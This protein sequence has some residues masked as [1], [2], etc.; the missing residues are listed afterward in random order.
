LA[1]SNQA[2]AGAGIR[3]VAWLYRSPEELVTGVREY[4]QAGAP[5]L[6]AILVGRLLE[7]LRGDTV[8]VL[9]MAELGRNPARLMPELRGFADEHPGRRVRVLAELAWPGRSAA[10]LREISRYEAMLE[11]A[12]AGVPVTV[13]C[14]Y[15]EAEL[16]APEITAARCSHRRLLRAGHELDSAD[17]QADAASSSLVGGPLIAPRGA[18]SLAYQRNLRPVRDLVGAVGA[19]AGL[20][21]ERCADLVIAASEVAANTLKHTSGGGI[22]RIWATADEVLCQLEDGGHITDPLAGYRRP[23]GDVAAGQGLWLVNQVCDLAEIRTSEAGTTIRLHMDRYP[24][25]TV[26]VQAR[27]PRAAAGYL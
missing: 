22:V 15:S 14:P 12:L 26:P 16:S 2:A 6:V 5:L 20:A 8:A 17:F 7:E 3:H 13:V 10:E 27:V 19:Q 21:A 18:Q 4:A 23:V 1:L 24:Q 25:K 9:D 11:L